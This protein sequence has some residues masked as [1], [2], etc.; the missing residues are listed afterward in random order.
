[1][2][3]TKSVTCLECGAQTDKISASRLNNGAGWHCDGCRIKITA[4]AEFAGLW[5]GS[6]PD[7]R[8]EVITTGGFCLALYCDGRVLTVDYD[9][10]F[11]VRDY[12]PTGWDDGEEGTSLYEGYDAAAAQAALIYGEGPILD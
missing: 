6:E 4:Q 12:G 2:N 1:M 9:D 10:E 8:P 11:L 7:P 3:T 5:G